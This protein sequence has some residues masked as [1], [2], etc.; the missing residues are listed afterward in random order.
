[1]KNETELTIPEYKPPQDIEKQAK[2]GFVFVLTTSDGGDNEIFCGVVANLKNV[3]NQCNY[4]IYEVEIDSEFY[5]QDYNLPPMQKF[6]EETEE[7]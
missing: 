7:T 5:D 3:K 4:C 6:T 1:M 2:P